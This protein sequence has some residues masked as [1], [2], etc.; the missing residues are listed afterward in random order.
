MS[1]ER[2]LRCYDYVNQPFPRVQEALRKDVAGILRRATTGAAERERDIA[3]QLHVRLGAIDVA[4]DVS[5]MIGP[6]EETMS[7]P[8]GYQVSVFPLQWQSL[9]APSLFPQMKAK[10]YVYPLSTRETQI[11]ID[12]TYTPPL[13]LLGDAIDAVVGHRIAQASVLHFVQDIAALLRSELAA[14]PEA[15]ETTRATG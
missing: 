7:S 5:I 9:S 8:W 13:G 4:A 3:A 15:A 12:G 2:I 11:E 6:V 1:T 14:Q 10:L